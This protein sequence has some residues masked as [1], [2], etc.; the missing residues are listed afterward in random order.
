[1]PE[2]PKTAVEWLS[3]LGLPDYIAMT[4]LGHLAPICGP[5]IWVDGNS[6]HYTREQYIGK[7]GVDPKVAWEAVKAYRRVTGKNDK[8]MRL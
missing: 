8:V 1:M 2:I 6:N 4:P 5:E 3:C 7:W